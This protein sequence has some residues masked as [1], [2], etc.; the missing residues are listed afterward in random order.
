MP[1]DRRVDALDGNVR[2]AVLVTLPLHQ[3]SLPH[4]LVRQLPVCA[5][6]LLQRP[7]EDLW[8]HGPPDKVRVEAPVVS[9]APQVLRVLPG[10]GGLPA[11]VLLQ[12]HLPY[13]LL[14]GPLDV[15]HTLLRQ[16]QGLAHPHLQVVQ[17][18]VDVQVRVVIAQRVLQHLRD[19]LKASHGPEDDARRHDV[20]PPPVLVRERHGVEHGKRY[21][22][23]LPLLQV[24]H[25]QGHADQ[26]LQGLAGVRDALQQG[27]VDVREAL[28]ESPG[29][30][31]G[32][33]EVVPQ[34]LHQREDEWDTQRLPSVP[35]RSGRVGAGARLRTD[36]LKVI[37]VLSASGIGVEERGQ[38]FAPPAALVPEV[39]SELVEALTPL[40]A[41]TPF[42]GTAAA[43]AA[44]TTPGPVMVSDLGRH[45]ALHQ[46]PRVSVHQR[47]L[48]VQQQP[49]KAREVEENRHMAIVRNGLAHDGTLHYVPVHG[50]GNRNGDGEPS[51]VHLC[52]HGQAELRWLQRLDAT[53]GE[54]AGVAAGQVV[55]VQQRA[56]ELGREVD[57]LHVSG[58]ALVECENQGEGC[59]TSQQLQ[60]PVR[61]EGGQP[62]VLQV[63]E[64][65]AVGHVSQD[66]HPD[67]LAGPAFPAHEPPAPHVADHCCPPGGSEVSAGWG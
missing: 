42:A 12:G 57:S 2:V 63:E 43:S 59:E 18:L 5:V 48:R 37:L 19:G 44:A 27:L 6:H 31:H 4:L 46:K 23:Q 51:H 25:G 66:L 52:G 13:Q 34:Q 45:V 38:V 50:E 53:L 30:V 14:G 67:L 20:R 65:V 11:G 15:P 24:C 28:R 62:P 35:P 58:I 61:N 64:Q 56:E 54:G 22:K 33:G 10:R 21:E 47:H 26:V 3:D 8:R 49:A 16:P 9:K 7:H 40:A 32:R 41:A 1:V 55:Q 60:G 29:L 17:H 36:R 39:H